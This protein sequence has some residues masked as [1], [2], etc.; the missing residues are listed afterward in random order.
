MALR[1]GEFV[2]LAANETPQ[3]LSPAAT[4]KQAA[5]WIMITSD[6]ANDPAGAFIGGPTVSLATKRGVPIAPGDSV[7]LPS[8]GDG[9]AAHDIRTT[10]ISGTIGDGFSWVYLT[11]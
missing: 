8:S 4:S 10:Y 2:T 6:S 3:A 7:L 1:D 9:G 11:R 5:C